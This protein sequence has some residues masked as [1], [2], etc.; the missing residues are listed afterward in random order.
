M[1]VDLREPNKAIT[2]DSHPL[3][4]KE[5][6]LSSLTG[7]TIFSTIDLA[8]AYHQ[9]LL[10]PE[11]RD[12][13][14]FITH[15]GL[16][17][18][19]RVPCGL[20]SASAAFQKLMATVLKGVSEVQYYLDNV[21]CYGCTALEHDTALE[22]VQQRL[23]LQLNEKKYHFRQASLKFLGHLVTA[24]V[25][26]PDTNHLQAITAPKD[27]ASLRSFLG[28]LSWYGKFISNYATVVE[29]LCACLCQDATFE[30]TD[31]AQLPHCETV[32]CG[33]PCAGLIQPRLANHNFDGCIRLRSGCH[34]LSGASRSHRT[35]SG[36]ST[37]E[38]EALACIWAVEK[39][40]TY[41]WS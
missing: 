6:L 28:M 15:E 5:E 26:Q 29:P 34:V 39:W 14:A 35:N 3:P 12:L 8:S 2:V 20:A 32:A 25:I 36:I 31:E 40:R 18:F 30:W 24:N 41:L 33:Q 13:T 27:A 1:C 19:C 4:H 22:T 21:T 37:V 23:S 38:K 7:A 16:F 17:R 11:S 10:H 9:V